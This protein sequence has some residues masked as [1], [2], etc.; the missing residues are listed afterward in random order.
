MAN[1]QGVNAQQFAPLPYDIVAP[2]RAAVK[3][4]G[5]AGRRIRSDKLGPLVVLRRRWRSSAGDGIAT[6]ACRRRTRDGATK[7]KPANT[8]RRVRKDEASATAGVRM[9]PTGAD[10]NP[11]QQP[12]PEGR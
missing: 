1:A 9:G 2:A 4:P 12:T 3:E 7:W 5:K 10:S 8:F 11:P 6:L